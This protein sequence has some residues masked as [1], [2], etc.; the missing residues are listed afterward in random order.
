MNPKFAH[1]IHDEGLGGGSAGR[2]AFV[3]MADQEVGTESDG[4]P[5]DEELQQVV[6]HHQH[7]HR[8]GKEG[9]VAEETGIAGLAPHVS[10]GIDVDERT[11]GRD[12]QQHDGGRAGRWRSRCEYR[13]CP[14]SARYRG[15]ACLVPPAT[16]KKTRSETATRRGRGRD[17]NEM[18][19]VLDPMAEEPENQERG[20]RKE[21]NEFVSHQMLNA[22]MFNQG[23]QYITFNN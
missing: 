14:R 7:Q 17:G 2:R 20:Q 8:K 21:R 15:E 6:G 9:D 3:P 23:S 4:F 12:E 11:H 1:P 5:E 10:D 22:L 18:G 16:S 19:V 13:A